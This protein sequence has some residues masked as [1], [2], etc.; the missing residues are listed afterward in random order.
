MAILQK[1]RNRAG[2][3]V[4]IFVGVALFL[5]IIDPTTF[6]SL[7][8]KNPTD[9]ASIN[10]HDIKYEEYLKIAQEHEDF[11]KVSQQTDNL[12]PET[13]ESVQQQA[14]MD[15][16][17]MYILDVNFEDL[18]ITVSDEELEDMLWGKHLSPIIQ[19]NFTNPQTGLIDTSMIK[20]YFQNAE[21][22]ETGKQ[23]FIAD[24]LKK[25]MVYEYQYGRLHIK[26]RTLI[27]KGL[28]VPTF[29]AKDDYYSKNN[30][31]DILVVA[32]NYKD[33]DDAVIKVS[34]ADIKNYYDEHI[35]R[36]QILE[37]NRDID[38]VIFDVFPSKEDTLAA[39]KDIK[40]NSKQFCT[41]E[42]ETVTDFL[43]SY[44]DSLYQE[45]YY[46]PEEFA[47]VG[48]FDPATMKTGDTSE[49]FHFQGSFIQA[50]VLDVSTRPD[51]VKASY[52]FIMADT[53]KSIEQVKVLADSIYNVLVK[54]ADFA[55]LAMQYS[56]H[57]ASKEK[58]G[59][60]GWLTESMLGDDKELKDATFLSKKGEIKKIETEFGVHIIKIDEQ[61]MLLQKFS[62]A[63]LYKNIKYSTQTA[64]MRF[65]QAS[66]F[67][68]KNNTAAKFDK[69]CIDLQLTKRMGNAIK[70]NDMKIPGLVN[71][72][73]I[74]KWAYGEEIEKGAVSPVF[75]LND[76]YVVAKV[77]TIREKGTA[78][79]EDVKE[80]IE[81]IVVKKKKAALLTEEFNKDLSKGE[82]LEAI[83][84][85][86]NKKLDTISNIT[87]NSM[88]LPG[89]GLEPNVTGTASV[90]DKGKTSKP[91]EGNNAVYVIAV[92][93]KVPAPA[94]TD[95]KD[96]QLYLMRSAASK[97]YQV[98]EVLKKIADIK[99]YRS[100]WM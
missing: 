63:Y 15:L 87:F 22:D 84:L 44:S 77:A 21:K 48:G 10:G 57:P 39:L 43:N 96:E 62:I 29:I 12:S 9:I 20:N 37:A 53:T 90:L 50:R 56:D 55:P 47:F 76:M 13:L 83:A 16:L 100:T 49:I 67:A 24:Y 52:M 70:E 46:R 1:I 93:N 66:E 28:Y 82:S 97:T 17:R 27:E 32:R 99:D 45:K 60:L 79:I 42:A 30:K 54:G 98:F 41:I 69:A 51:S 7:F 35:E 73:S 78:A 91:I 26:Y 33:V 34:D 94:K 86:Y 64:Q 3:F 40:T 36:F 85:K 72:R 92:V 89:Y 68:S 88:S 8:H 19:Q 75:E 81:P 11:L 80:Q 14:W 23:L 5:F 59:D 6:N 61:T 2:I 71:P 74:I 4:I 58:G 25:A 31:A 95:F 38:F 65:S 18:G